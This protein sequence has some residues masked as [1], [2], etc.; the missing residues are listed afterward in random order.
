METF[1]AEQFYNVVDQVKPRLL[2]M[3]VNQPK[4]IAEQLSEAVV[5]LAAADFPDR[6]PT[7]MTD[8]VLQANN[9]PAN[10]SRVVHLMASLTFKFTYS[11]RSD[12]LYS[13]I[14]KVCDELHNYLFSTMEQAVQAV[15]GDNYHR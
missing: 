5:N 11:L 10:L 1:E 6:W 4:I 3:L 7:L 12:P 8:L 13:E 9:S 14:I 15:T 2:S